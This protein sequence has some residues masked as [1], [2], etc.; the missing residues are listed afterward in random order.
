M[1]SC[2]LDDFA[3]LQSAWPLPS[4]SPSF[5]SRPARGWS[6]KRPLKPAEGPLKAYVAKEDKSYHWTKRREGK[7]GKGT[8]VELT[9]TSQTWKNIV[10]KHQLFIYRPVAGEKL[11]PG[12]ADDRRRVV[13]FRSS[14]NPSPPMRRSISMSA[15]VQQVKKLPIWPSISSRRSPC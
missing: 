7:L 10:W 2:R 11:R 12:L 5:L 9:L 14:S 6:P 8:V 3:T 13:G 15:G 4:S 1:N